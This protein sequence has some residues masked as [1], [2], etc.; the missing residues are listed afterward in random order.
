MEALAIPMPAPRYPARHAATWL[1]GGWQLFRRA[2]VRIMMLS[3][4]PIVFEALCQAVP[5]AGILLSK[6]L[7]PL[8]SALAL[9]MLDQRIR[10][11]AFGVP[12]AIATW[13]SRLPS[14][15]GLGVACLVV[16]VFQMALAAALAGP[17][18]AMALALGDMAA[19]RMSRPQM[20]LVLASGMLPGLALLYVIP[21]VA[22]DGVGILAA[23]GDNAR[24]LMLTW[25][26]ALL[27]SLATALLVGGLLWQPW[28]LAILLPGGFVV[29]YAMYRD[30][31]GPAST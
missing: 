31:F 19:L 15:L 3:L 24:M 2:P 11:G 17:A 6:L 10:H 23:L 27:L 12:A 22:L 1:R 5:G 30:V 13:R 20:A 18:Q 21:R 14:L 28:L 8:L 25:R 4:M 29:G 16:F 9:L 26:P 7:T